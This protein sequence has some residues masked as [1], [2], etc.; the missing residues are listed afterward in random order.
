ME[1]TIKLMNKLF[2]IYGFL[3]C[4]VLAQNID[5]V[6]LPP[7]N[8]EDALYLFTAWKLEGLANASVHLNYLNEL[9]DWSK[10]ND[11]LALVLF[12]EADLESNV[13]REKYKQLVD[14]KWLKDAYYAN[15][16]LQRILVLEADELLD[17]V[18]NKQKVVPSVHSNYQLRDFYIKSGEKEK[19]QEILLK[20]WQ[21]TQYNPTLFNDLFL[22]Y[23]ENSALFELQEEISK[24]KTKG[25]RV[26]FE[27]LLYWKAQEWE[28]LFQFWKEN[29]LQ[30]QSL[31]W[32]FELLQS[33]KP[34]W[35]TS[36]V[37]YWEE[38]VQKEWGA[39]LWKWSQYLKKE[40]IYCEQIPEVLNHGICV[41]DSEAAVLDKISFEEL[42]LAIKN[43]IIK[44]NVPQAKSL[45][46]L[47]ELYPLN[48]KANAMA[49][50]LQLI[51]KEEWEMVQLYAI[52]EEDEALIAFFNGESSKMDFLILDLCKY[53][54]GND[55]EQKSILLKWSK[56]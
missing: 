35:T 9:I 19:L 45:A 38:R 26:A 28:L 22:L 21:Q 34:S 44:G 56:E 31:L 53:F 24:I 47:V 50:G 10:S 23:Q 54:V 6:Q 15:L 18:L 12:L 13:R 36:D 4:S 55:K 17:D 11:T 39:L 52:D 5:K 2:W 1:T 43:Q 7:Q 8:E 48:V 42:P 3:A 41:N 46:F 40:K 49:Y 37:F 32:P 20:L 14:A 51:S 29:D 30:N 33:A 25:R 27:E 16:I